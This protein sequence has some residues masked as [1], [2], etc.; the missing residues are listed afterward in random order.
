MSRSNQFKYHDATTFERYQV[1]MR[2]L[3][4]RIKALKKRVISIIHSH[5]Y[6]SRILK[7]RN[8][9]VCFLIILYAVMNSFVDLRFPGITDASLRPQI[10][11]V[12]LSGYFYG[13]FYGFLTGFLGN[14][15]GD[16]LLGLGFTYIWTF[17]VANGIYGLVMGLFPQRRD[18]LKSIKSFSFLVTFLVITNLAGIIYVLITMAGTTDKPIADLIHLFILPVFLSN[19]W[20]TMTLIPFLLWVFRR[21][22]ITYGIRLHFLLYYFTII[23]IFITGAIIF[24]QIEVES[25]HDPAALT[26]MFISLFIPVIILTLIGITVSKHISDKFVKPVKIIHQTLQS[27]GKSEYS[28]T[29]I[30]EVTKREDELGD[31]AKSIHDLAAKLYE[32]ELKMVQVVTRNYGLTKDDILSSMEFYQAIE[33][34]VDEGLE[35]PE[36]DITNIEAISLIISVSGLSELSQSYSSDRLQEQGTSEKISFIQKQD[37]QLAF[38]M[39]I[40]SEYD[41]QKIRLK[42]YLDSHLAKRLLFQ[43]ILLRGENK[44]FV[45]YVEDENIFQVLLTNWKYERFPQDME[46]ITAP[47]SISLTSY[48]TGFNR[49]YTVIYCHNELKHVKQLI[50]LMKTQKISAKIQIK[51]K[52]AVFPYLKEWELDTEKA[53]VIKDLEEGKRLVRRKEFD[54]EFEFNSRE[55]I[56]RFISIVNHYSKREFADKKIL[57]GSWFEPLIIT[58]R[59]L[60]D[61]KKAHRTYIETGKLRY[62]S[63]TVSAENNLFKELLGQPITEEVWVTEGFYQYLKG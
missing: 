20:I 2:T 31:L 57:F 55:D 4:K 13:P 28:R 49:D 23:S 26:D 39:D 48:E 41:L 52:F 51:P 21:F 7:N 30:L 45:G 17:S 62:L 60:P 32:K 63:Y 46:V 36:S 42:D 1:F 44:N 34:I 29:D 47:H 15:A 40:I 8:T 10:V 50:G 61:L 16:I 12:F 14:I 27:M 38:D 59:P 19:T 6:I 33:K 37:L 11:I 53:E 24:S 22:R 54:I 35:K 56:I 18:I 9:V 25:L 43:L 5:P 3:M 58:F